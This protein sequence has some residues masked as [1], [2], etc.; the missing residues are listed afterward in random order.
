MGFLRFG[1]FGYCSC[2]EFGELVG[3]EFDEKI[4][5]D[6]KGRKAFFMSIKVATEEHVAKV[7]LRLIPDPAM[8]D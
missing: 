2:N 3:T 5:Q 6:F 1:P 7:V 8:W 4:E